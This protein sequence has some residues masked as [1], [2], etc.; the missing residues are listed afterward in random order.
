MESIY[1]Q[2]K[3][4]KECF[5]NIYTMMVIVGKKILFGVDK[6]LVFRTTIKKWQ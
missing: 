2:L 4:Y 5:N 1:I 6:K 3:E